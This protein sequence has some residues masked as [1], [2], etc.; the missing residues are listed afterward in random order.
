MPFYVPQSLKNRKS[1]GYSTLPAY[2]KV[3]IQNQNAIDKLKEQGLLEDFL[4]YQKSP[5]LLSSVGHGVANAGSGILDVLSRPMYATTAA[6]NQTWGGEPGATAPEIG[7]AVIAGGRELL[8]GI[9]GIEGTKQTP[10]ELFR[11]KVPAYAQFSK[12][13]PYQSIATDFALSLGLDPTVVAGAPLYRSAA[14]ALRPAGKVL[15]ATAKA[16]GETKVGNAFGEAFIPGFALKK[17]PGG[18]AV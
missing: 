16:F 13:H 7:K 18:E 1:S 3:D 11:A 15:G 17:A 5:S 14:E 9:G 10:G 12:E 4:K 6:L 2:Q 8:S